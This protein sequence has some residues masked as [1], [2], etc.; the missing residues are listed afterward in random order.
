M[1]HPRVFFA[2]LA[3]ALL[4]LLA[5]S[6]DNTGSRVNLPGPEG[7]GLDS[8]ALNQDG[9]TPIQ[10]PISCN[11]GQGCSGTYP[12]QCSCASAA[13]TLPATCDNGIW[14]PASEPPT[15][16]LPQPGQCPDAPPAQGSAC[17]AAT[18][19]DYA[20]RGTT[21][22]I[23]CESGVWCGHVD[24]GCSSLN[25]PACPPTIPTPATQ[26]AANHG[27][28]YFCLYPCVDGGASGVTGICTPDAQGSATGTWSLSS[29]NACSADAGTDGSTDAAGD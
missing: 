17:S 16:V 5:C 4:L 1:L 8:A 13:G 14:C 19:C 26:C 15:H 27:P 7:G 22:T 2:P 25:P 12:N 10:C 6:T 3:S 21:V 18:F 11:M 9:N 23:S 24:S 28:R 20:C 29:P